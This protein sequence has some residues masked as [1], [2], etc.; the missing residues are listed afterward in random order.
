[1][2]HTV[3]ASVLCSLTLSAASQ[4]AI[5]IAGNNLGGSGRVL[6][7]STGTPLATGSAVRVG[8][9]NDPVADSA[10]ISG[11]NFTAIDA[12]F[13]SLGEGLVNS[14]SV[15][16]GAL[17]INSTP[18]R[19]S[20]QIQNIQQSYLPAGKQMFYW[21]FNSATPAA[22][23][24]WAIFTNNDASGGGSPWVSVLENPEVPGSGDLTLAVQLTRVDDID[25]V[26]SGS[27]V[28]N[29]LRTVP[30]PGLAALFLT[31]IPLFLR[32]RRS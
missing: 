23:D 14:G 17:S 28:D 10:I 32:R 30:E 11:T 8:F 4:A 5:S 29:Q 3:F 12:I 27:L 18:G 15:A 20:F 22:A 19:F 9:F 7:D 6:A 21:V 13:K 2:K 1:M 26:I 16:A 24:E 25:D 31:A